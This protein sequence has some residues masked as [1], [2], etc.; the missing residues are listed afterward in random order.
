MQMQLNSQPCHQNRIK[1]KINNYR[2]Q[3]NTG[4]SGVEEGVLASEVDL[5]DNIKSAT[6]IILDNINSA[7]IIIRRS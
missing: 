6:L 1:I 2:Y 4:S 7:T 5:L 3:C